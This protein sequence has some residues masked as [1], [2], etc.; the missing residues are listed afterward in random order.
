MLCE[1]IQHIILNREKIYVTILDIETI[2]D[3]DFRTTA[4]AFYRNKLFVPEAL[5]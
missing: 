3:T 4:N 5:L 1:N 2:G